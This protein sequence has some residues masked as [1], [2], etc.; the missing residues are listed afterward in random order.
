MSDDRLPG[1]WSDLVHDLRDALGREYPS[2]TVTAMTADRGWLHVDVDDSK[3]GPDARYQL[4]RR[5]QGF[6]TQSLSTCMCCGSNHGRDR[7]ERRVVTC[8]ECNEETCDA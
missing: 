4:G 2:V 1:G 5:I 3:L 8:D 7:G 6:V